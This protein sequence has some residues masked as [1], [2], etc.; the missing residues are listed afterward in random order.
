MR[1]V[2]VDAARLGR[3]LD[4]FVERHGTWQ[5]EAGADTVA[6]TG[7]DGAQAWIEVPYGPLADPTVRGLI[8]HVRRP[9]CI[10]VLLVRRAGHAAG[11][12]DG[13]TLVRSKVDSSYVQGTT[14]AG[15]WSQQRY[16]RRRANQASAAFADA[17]DVAVRVFDG[18]PIE[19]LVVGGDRAAVKSVLADPRLAHVAQLVGGPWLT[20]KDPKLKLL[21]AMPEQ[22]LAVRIA[23]DP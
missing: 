14:K 11:V 20:V 19:V 1:T 16:A 18:Q 7:A 23:L 3:W 5:V 9:R 10:G 22:F 17:A 12:F 6:L 15:G 13:S 4:G 8:E 2:Q 21:E